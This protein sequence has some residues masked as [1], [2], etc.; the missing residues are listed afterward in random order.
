MGEREGFVG[1]H[2]RETELIERELAA[3]M[4]KGVFFAEGKSGDLSK[5]L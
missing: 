1:K 2:T 5:E 4:G 3:L